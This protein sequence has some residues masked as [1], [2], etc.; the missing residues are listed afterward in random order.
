MAVDDG[1][2][3]LHVLPA[4]DRRAALPRRRTVDPPSRK[5]RLACGAP[6][7]TRRSSNAD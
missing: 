1:A 7:G 2:D 3:L 4:L 6:A 5:S